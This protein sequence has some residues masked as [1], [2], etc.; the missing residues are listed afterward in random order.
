MEEENLGQSVLS[1][2]EREIQAWNQC[3]VRECE[4]TRP[5]PGARKGCLLSLAFAGQP[6]DRVLAARTDVISR[7]CC[8]CLKMGDLPEEGRT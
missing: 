7:G 2:E 4:K 6:R 3:E 5:S 1:S 8:V